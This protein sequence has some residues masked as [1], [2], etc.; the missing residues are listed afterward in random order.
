[1]KKAILFSILAILG[2]A[3]CQSQSASKGYTDLDVA[4]FKQKMAE[5]GV[6]L[7]DVR[8]PEETAEG[9]IAADCAEIDFEADGFE[10]KIDKLD[11]D[12]TYL[13]YCQGGTRSAQA[14]AMMAGKGFKHIYNLT[15]GYSAWTEGK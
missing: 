14:S 4:A 15:G 10:A 8:T 1:M 3:S 7:L 11:K 5:P 6:I 2:L 13:I 12:K 9:K